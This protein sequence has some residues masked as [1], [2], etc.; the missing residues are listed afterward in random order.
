RPLSATQLAIRAALKNAPPLSVHKPVVDDNQFVVFGDDTQSVAPK[1]ASQSLMDRFLRHKKTLA[2]KVNE[3]PTKSGPKFTA[4]H[5]WTQLKTIMT[6]ELELKRA[7][8]EKERELNDLIE[9]EDIDGGDGDDEEADELAEQLAYE[10]K[11]DGIAEEDQKDGS[12]CD[13]NDGKSDDEEEEEE[14]EEAGSDAEDEG[15]D[16]EANP[17]VDD[18][19]EDSDADSDEEVETR[20]DP[21]GDTQRVNDKCSQDIG[22]NDKNEESVPVVDDN[23]ID[24]EES[25]QKSQSTEAIADEEE[26]EESDDKFNDSLLNTSINSLDESFERRC[27]TQKIAL[28]PFITQRPKPRMTDTNITQLIPKFDATGDEFDSQTLLGLCSGAFGSQLSSI[29]ETGEKSQSTQESGVVDTDDDEEVGEKCM[30]DARRVRKVFNVES[31]G[32]SEDEEKVNTKAKQKSKSDLKSEI[33]SLKSFNESDGEELVVTEDE[34]SDEE[35]AEGDDEEAD[36]SDGDDNDEEEV[37]NEKDIRKL[38]RG[39]FEDEAELSG[40]DDDVSSDEEEGEGDNHYDN[41]EGDQEDLP[42]ESEMRN[43]IERIHNKKLLDED[44]RQ[45]MVLKDMM[46]ADGDLH[47]DRDVREKKFRWNFGEEDQ[48]FVNDYI[49]EDSEGDYVDSDEEAAKAVKSPGLKLKPTS[50]TDSAAKTDENF[51]KLKSKFGLNLNPLN[52]SKDPNTAVGAEK[53]SIR[54]DSFVVRDE[55]LKTLCAPKR[56]LPVNNGHSYRPNKK[57]KNS[58]KTS[59]KKSIFDLF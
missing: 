59:A 2:L 49:N 30:S 41:E 39:F 43:Q 32:E 44:K 24:A 22:L 11:E 13:G 54:I 53:K 57:L 34:V 20:A 37:V 40:S 14:E 23:E 52:K 25:Q 51:E 12:D 33:S 5:K 21:T 46:F 58:K 31:D 28:S 7:E 45:L 35:A 55:R 10:N 3:S 16:R 6:Q 36:G 38:S 26:E 8:V 27:A 15:S 4:G 48:T 50:E 56:S 47:D 9:N 18:E 17:F 42:S 19:A 1:T 29:P